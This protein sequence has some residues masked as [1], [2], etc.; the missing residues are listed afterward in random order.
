MGDERAYHI[1]LSIEKERAAHS[2]LRLRSFL[3]QFNGVLPQQY[4]DFLMRGGD[5][6]D[7]ATEYPREWATAVDE[8]WQL[9]LGKE[10]PDQRLNRRIDEIREQSGGN[11]ILIGGPPCQAY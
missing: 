1:A 11:S 8:A 4:Y 6:P 9:E 2:T 10:D 3:R 7:W 5:E